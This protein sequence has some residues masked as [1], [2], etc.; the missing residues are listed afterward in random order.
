MRDV[1][2]SVGTSTFYLY[3]HTDTQRDDTAGVTGL[4]TQAGLTHG[5]HTD[6]LINTTT[7]L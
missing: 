2:E 5:L 3:M 6:I 1:Q 7:E 4:M